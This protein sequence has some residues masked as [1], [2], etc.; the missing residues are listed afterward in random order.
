MGALYRRVSDVWDV[1]CYS[2]QAFYIYTYVF[3]KMLFVLNVQVKDWQTR[4]STDPIKNLSKYNRNRFS[5]RAY[6]HQTSKATLT[7]LLFL[8]FQ[9]GEV[10]VDV[11][12][13]HK[14]RRTRRAIDTAALPAMM[15]QYE[16]Q[17]RGNTQK[18]S[19]GEPGVAFYR[20]KSPT[21]ENTNVPLFILCKG[22]PGGHSQDGR[23]QLFTPCETKLKFSR[24]C[25][26][27]SKTV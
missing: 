27:A 3:A 18:L 19:C 25:R 14:T 7:V 5:Y 23:F 20:L 16:T 22:P 10:I 13:F 24:F 15:L 8:C 9:L 21:Q 26:T 17:L 6:D 4:K 12:R 2:S 11:L 1:H